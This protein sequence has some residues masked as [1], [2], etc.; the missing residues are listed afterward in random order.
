M[1]KN[2]SIVLL[3]LIATMSLASCGGKK[4]SQVR[5][6]STPD[7]T[8]VPA[9][10]SNPGESS[11]PEENPVVP[12]DIDSLNRDNLKDLVLAK[13]YEIDTNTIGDFLSK[14]VNNSMN[15]AKSVKMYEGEKEYTDMNIIMEEGH[16]TTVAYSTNYFYRKSKMIRQVASVKTE[17]IYES[18]SIVKDGYEYTKISET[19]YFD[20]YDVSP[21]T[22]G[23]EQNNKNDFEATLF[24]TREMALYPFEGMALGIATNDGVF[25]YGEVN[26]NTIIMAGKGSMAY[27]DGSYTYDGKTYSCGE[28]TDYFTILVISKFGDEY[29]VTDSFIDASLYLDYKYTSGSYYPLSDYTF[30]E[31]HTMKVSYDYQAPSFN[32]DTFINTFP[33][34]YVCTFSFDAYIVNETIDS[35]TKA[36]TAISATKKNAVS[37][38][39]D[40][41]GNTTA[42]ASIPLESN[43][44]YIAGSIGVAQFD[45]ATMTYKYTT[46]DAVMT[47]DQLPYNEKVAA[48][49]F[50]GTDY[51]KVDPSYQSKLDSSSI[52]VKG[53]LTINYDLTKTPVTASVSLKN[54]YEYYDLMGD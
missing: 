11:N 22:T 32:K 28:K 24:Q 37:L 51:Y 35:E 40:E 19:N 41:K 50:D 13:E 20:T 2:F 12:F 31:G 44:F 8:S 6:T 23:T 54:L 17:E 36:V 39:I 34:T 33:K 47:I 3:S 4:S 26:E 14:A 10:S 27:T 18:T 30:Y 38:F 49:N 9:E 45:K 43:N 52:R 21:S 15:A 29:R 5:E 48:I 7:E 25:K 46:I 16:E 53:D 1:K 42:V